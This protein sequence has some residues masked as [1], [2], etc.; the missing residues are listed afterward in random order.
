VYLSQDIGATRVEEVKV[1][2][3][4]LLATD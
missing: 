2:E 3:I 4:P 1:V